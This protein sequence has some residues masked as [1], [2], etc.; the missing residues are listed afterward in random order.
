MCL[1]FVGERTLKYDRE[2]QECRWRQI[3]SIYRLY[4]DL[5]VKKLYHINCL[6]AWAI[7]VPLSEIKSYVVVL[8]FYIKMMKR[9]T[10]QVCSFKAYHQKGMFSVQDKL[11]LF[12]SDREESSARFPPPLATPLFRGGKITPTKYSQL[13]A[14]IN[15]QYES[16]V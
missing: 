16:S 1:N 7:I 3:K 4:L 10:L 11:N 2:N 5:V 9:R 8:P 14:K 6:N 15:C 13:L 12:Q